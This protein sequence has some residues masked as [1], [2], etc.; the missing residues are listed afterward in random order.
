[1]STQSWTVRAASCDLAAVDVGMPGF[2]VLVSL[3]NAVGR[4]C[5]HGCGHRDG[6]DGDCGEHSGEQRTEHDGGRGVVW[7][8]SELFL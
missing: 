6:R 3:D 1:V 7:M 2:D 5:T 4:L 8:G